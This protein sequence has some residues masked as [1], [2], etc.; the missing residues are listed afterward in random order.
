MATHSTAYVPTN[1]APNE[2]IMSE[3]WSDGMLSSTGFSW[4]QSTPRLDES[5]RAVMLIDG[6]PREPMRVDPPLMECDLFTHLDG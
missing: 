3:G 6:S 2:Y 5:I 4:Y 1:R